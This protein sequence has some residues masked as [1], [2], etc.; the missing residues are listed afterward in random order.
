M[1]KMGEAGTVWGVPRRAPTSARSALLPSPS[2]PTLTATSRPPG[3]CRAKNTPAQVP[4]PSSTGC[5]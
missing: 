5:P 4:L 1:N 3:R 2:V